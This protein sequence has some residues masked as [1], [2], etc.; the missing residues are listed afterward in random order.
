[1]KVRAY[2]NLHQKCWSLKYRDHPVHHASE[3]TLEDVRFVVQPSGRARVRREKRKNVH[4]FV[5]GQTGVVVIPRPTVFRAS[6]VTDAITRWGAPQRL[7]YDPYRD[8]VDGFFVTVP[9]EPVPVKCAEL[10]FLD[11]NGRA[12]GWG[13]EEAA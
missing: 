11:R 9:C 1:M 2:R 6:L 12:W 3:V 10:V 5:E 4:A 7:H 8:D 13:V